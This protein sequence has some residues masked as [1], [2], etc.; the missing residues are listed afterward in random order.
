MT[1]PLV[2]ECDAEHKHVTLKLHH[3]HT[4]PSPSHFSLSVESNSTCV[5]WVS[6]MNVFCGE[7]LAVAVRATD[8]VGNIESTDM[9]L[10]L[11]FLGISGPQDKVIRNIQSLVPLK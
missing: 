9:F 2:A 6:K 7:T 3:T 10:V 11:V 1:D 4:P 8:R 5:E